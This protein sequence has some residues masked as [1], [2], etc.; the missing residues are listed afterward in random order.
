MPMLNLLKNK[1]SASLIE[2]IMVIL[3]IGIISAIVCGVVIYFVQ[4]FIYSPRQLDVEKVALEIS[5]TM[6]EGNPNIRGLRFTQSI[7]DASDTQF[8]YTYGY[9]TAADQLSVRF[10]WD[11]GDGHIY[12][13][14]STDGGSNWS[15]ESVIPYYISP[16][17][18]IDGK[19]TPGVIFT[20]KKAADAAWVSG[21]D[22]LADIRRVVIEV[23]LKTGAGSFKD[24]QGDVDILTSSEIKDFS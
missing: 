2:L 21:S 4:L 11:N 13:S 15:A 14:T 16:G 9:P 20:Y 1:R 3:V 24:F 10:R 17:V 6:I 8:S 5:S 18:T 7:I 23:T 12:R 22:P 19:D